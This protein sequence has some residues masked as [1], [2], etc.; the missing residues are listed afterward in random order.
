MNIFQEIKLA[1]GL[2]KIWESEEKLL[3]LKLTTSTWIQILA[4]G[5]DVL[6]LINPVVAPEYKPYIAVALGI[7][8]ILINRISHLSNP[9]GTD[10][11]VAYEPKREEN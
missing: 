2:K 8:H 1:V 4:G 11:K 9:D 3:R 5:L 6:N 10:A 7:V